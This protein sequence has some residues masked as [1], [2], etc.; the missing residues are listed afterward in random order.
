MW[1]S[2]RSP[3]WGVVMRRFASRKVRIAG[4]VQRLLAL[5]VVGSY[6]LHNELVSRATCYSSAT[7]KRNFAASTDNEVRKLNMCVHVVCFGQRG[8]SRSRG[9]DRGTGAHRGWRSA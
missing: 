1:L 7:A 4:N 9:P 6:P 5:F 3:F 8:G 2:R